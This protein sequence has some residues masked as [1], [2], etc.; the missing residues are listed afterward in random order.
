MPS[1]RKASLSGP[2][3]AGFAPAGLTLPTPVAGCGKGG[4]LS[5]TA[6]PPLSAAEALAAALQFVSQ[7]C[8]EAPQVA[9]SDP[10]R[11]TPAQTCESALPCVCRA[12]HEE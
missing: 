12:C 2:A 1:P 8:N 7:R 6:P 10:C 11:P 4:G 3:T 5:G 9:Y